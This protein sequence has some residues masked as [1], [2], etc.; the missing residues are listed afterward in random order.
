MNS[1]CRVSPPTVAGAQSRHDQNPSFSIF[2]NGRRWYDHGTGEGGDI[3]RFIAKARGIQEPSAY[4]WLIKFAKRQPPSATVNA[5]MPPTG[6]QERCLDDPATLPVLPDLR[7]GTDDELE[8]LSRLRGVS[9]Q[10]LLFASAKGHLYFTEQQG[11]PVWLVTDSKR[12]NAQA[13]RLDGGLWANGSKVMGFSKSCGRW[14]VGILE[15]AK[16]DR[17]MLVEGTPDL[18]AA[19]H[20]VVLEKRCNQVA[21]ACMTGGSAGIHEDAYMGFRDKTVRIMAHND[22]AGQEAALRW[23]GRLRGGHVA[24]RCSSSRGWSAPMVSLSKT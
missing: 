20:F 7:V 18:L 17:I 23:A 21:P 16:F 19:Y 9:K 2:A 6:F 10:A 11:Y 12:C 4:R 22:P 1:S 5:V 24:L 13:R 8:A 14:P 3:V 15:A